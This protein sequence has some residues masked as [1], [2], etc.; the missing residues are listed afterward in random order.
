MVDA[1]AGEDRDRTLGGQVAVE[2]RL[3]DV[4]HGLA[5]FRVSDRA[6]AVA[7]ALA[8][9]HAIRRLAR[10]VLEPIGHGAHVGFEA[11]RRADDDRA[12]ATA[13][14]G[15]VRRPEAQGDLVHFSSLPLRSS[16]L[17]EHLG[18][19]LFEEILE[20]LLGLVA[21]LGDRRHQR[22]GQQAAG[23]VAFEDARQRVQDGE[24]GG[25]RV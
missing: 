7:V 19:A 12:V 6:P 10:P 22:F 21:G 5:R 15:D 4:T 24:I 20:P 13:L 18:G 17:P 8:E 11:A 3:R 9:E 14:D 1:V 16:V 25:Q 23:W 2:Q